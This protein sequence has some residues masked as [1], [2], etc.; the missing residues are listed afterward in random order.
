MENKITNENYIE[1]F[2]YVKN[3]LGENDFNATKIEKFPF[4]ISSEHIW[5]VFNWAKRLVDTDEYKNL[6]VESLLIA[7]IFHDVGYA[8]SPNSENHA[9]NSEIIFKKYLKENN[10]KKE[11]ENFIAFLVKNHSKKEL[12]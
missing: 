11:K 5:R 10:F 8:I 9:G 4:R 2:I 12:M 6:D 1:L 3:Q 7:T